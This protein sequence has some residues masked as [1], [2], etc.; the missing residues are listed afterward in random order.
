LFWK[1]KP[2]VAL[3]AASL[4]LSG[5]LSTKRLQEN[6]KLL[7]RQTIEAPKG[8]NK[9]A[10]KDLLVQKTNSKFGLAVPMYYL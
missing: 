9:D 4:L 7:Y 6:Q 3:A 8:I 10:I 5:C 2:V 1:K